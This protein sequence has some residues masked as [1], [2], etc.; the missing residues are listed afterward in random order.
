VRFNYA[1]VG[2]GYWTMLEPVYWLI[3]SAGAFGTN[4]ISFLL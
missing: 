4:L 3:L 1:Q 2:R